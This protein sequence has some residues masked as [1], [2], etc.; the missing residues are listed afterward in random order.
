[1]ERSRLLL[2]GATV[3]CV[4]ASSRAAF[5]ADC[6]VDSVNG[7]DSND[8]KSATTPV[9]SQTAIPSSGCTTMHYA[10]GSRFAQALKTITGVTTY[11]SYGDSSQ[12]LP[13]FKL[14]QGTATS[15]FQTFTSVTVDGLKFEGSHNTSSNTTAFMSGAGIC[16]Y[17]QGSNSTIKNSEITD[18]DFGIMLQGNGSVAT[19]NYV[20]DINGQALDGSTSAD[21]NSVGGGKGIYVMA[22]DC[23]VSYNTIINTITFPQWTGAQ[24]SSKGGCDGGAT[25]IAVGQSG[26]TLKGY[27]NHHNFAYYTCGFFQASTVAGNSGSGTFQDSEFYYN[28]MIDS[29]WMILAQVNNTSFVNMKW[30]NNTVVQHRAAGA[31][32]DQGMLME[33][34]NGVSSGVSGGATPANQIFLTNNLMIMNGVNDFYDFNAQC[35][36]NNSSLTSNTP[37]VM[38]SNIFLNNSTFDPGF[39]KLGDGDPGFVNTSDGTQIPAARDYDLTADTIA[40][41][42]ALAGNPTTIAGGAP[43]PGLTVD[44]LGREVPSPTTGKTDIGAFQYSSPTAADAGPGGPAPPPGTGGSG[45]ATSTGGSSA[46][47]STGASAVE[48]G[49]SCE[50]GGKRSEWVVVSLLVSM[51]F[52]WSA[53]RRRKAGRPR[54]DTTL[55]V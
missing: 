33:M 4:L 49:C 47:P 43:I 15:V 28:V 24:G 37:M 7:K 19:S 51:A 12:P 54:A 42:N 1:M 45:G 31:T 39:L 41:A 25:E 48:A 2:S 55:S 10:R 52:G 30:E 20:H 35:C 36:A 11:T 26:G 6:Y 16:V 27:K 38:T 21:P 50:V 23:E 53:R 34:W 17:L 5:A 9:Q 46:G 40:I 3:L 8:G 14:A 18:C 44:F 13:D 32:A 22:N 29:A